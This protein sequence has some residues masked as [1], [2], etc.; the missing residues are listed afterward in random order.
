MTE[1]RTERDARDERE[2]YERDVN[3]LAIIQQATP[4]SPRIAELE[5]KIAEYEQKNPAQAD[6]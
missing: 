1:P 2:E 6:R 3:R 4:E 5:R